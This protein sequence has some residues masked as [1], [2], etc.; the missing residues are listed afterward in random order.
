M[1]EM[2]RAGGL[3]LDQAPPLA[4]P[5]TF[6]ASAPFAVFA[7]GALLAGNGSTGL[8]SHWLP[9]T[10]ALTHLGTLGF[11]AMVMMG[12]LYQIIPVVAGAPVRGARIAHVV[13][14]LLVLGLAGLVT[15]LLTAASRVTF[16]S[17]AVLALALLLFLPPV[18]VA[19]ARA[20]AR[21]ESV[22]GMRLA[23]ANLFVV[24]FLGLW[25]A[26]GHIGM[27]F[28]GP[29]SLWIQ[30]HLGVGFLGWVGCL[31]SAVSWQV[32]PMFY[33]ASS[34]HR[35]P[36]R[37]TVA[38][39]ALG[40]LLPVAVL[41]SELGGWI[42]EGWPASAD[43][44][45]VGVLPAGIAV[46]VLQPA[47]S[48]RG[49]SLRRR[50]RIDHSRLFWRAGLCVAFPTAAA[51]PAAYLLP[52]PRWGLLLGWLAIWGWAGMIVHG[53]LT[54]IVPFLVW[55]HRFSPRIGHARVPSLRSL[56]PDRRTRLG[57][58]LH[59]ASLVAGV[60]AIASGADWLARGTGLLLMATAA[61]L[62]HSLFH[63]LRQRPDETESGR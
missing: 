26:H 25:M 35:A 48:L 57:F 16:A 49:L 9:Q 37:A 12:A 20:P 28:P 22:A 31:I 53:M 41:I 52:D 4:I 59:M 10:L 6:F 38:L 29:R 61:Q 2:L 62:G 58:F 34:Q 63:V 39:V 15:G 50:R 55:F 27:K 44:A 24:G 11:L 1:S 51:A 14:A 5:M 43:L 30:V 19:L 47:L 36:K 17:L 23:V 7:A 56:L 8:T 18:A 45:A 33:M 32:L 46:W 42:P 40:V 13:H 60:V 54:R 3:H 21:N